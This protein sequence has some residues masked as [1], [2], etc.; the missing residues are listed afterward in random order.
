[1][2]SFKNNPRV[3]LLKINRS[4]ISK[5]MTVAL[6]NMEI[7]MDCTLEKLPMPLSLDIPRFY[8]MKENVNKKKD[9]IQLQMLWKSKPLLCILISG[10]F[11]TRTKLSS[12]LFLSKPRLKLGSKLSLINIKRFYIIKDLSLKKRY[13]GLLYLR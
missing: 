5:T 2:I 10:R 9:Q 3:Y 7:T 11:T 4:F 6:R 13:R 1:M 8:F 12:K